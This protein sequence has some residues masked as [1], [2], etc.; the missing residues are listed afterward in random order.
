MAN[1][2]II[3]LKEIFFTELRELEKNFKKNLEEISSSL[4]EN[5]KQNEE[6]I[7]FAIQKNEQLYDKM[8]LE[9]NNLDK[10]G[11]LD[12]SQ[13]KLNDMIIS[14]EIKI[15][16][17]INSNKK[18]NL[19]YEKILSDNLTV[20]GFIGRSCIYKNLSEY[21]HHNI[22]DIER[23]KLEKEAEKKIVEDMKYKSDGL[24]KTILN[25]VENSVLRCNRYTDNKHK[26]IEEVLHNKLV[27]INEKNMDL[28]TQILTNLYATN[29]RVDNFQNQIKELK[30]MKETIKNDI[31]NILIDFHKKI[32][33]LEKNMENNIQKNISL[34][35][36]VLS[37]FISEIE[38]NIS[39]QTS[40]RQNKYG[41]KDY[42]S[43]TSYGKQ[44]REKDDLNAFLQ[45]KS[46]KNISAKL[47][48]DKFGRNRGFFKRKTQVFNA[49]NN[50][51]YMDIINKIDE[52]NDSNESNHSQKISIHNKSLEKE[53][54][55]ENSKEI[56]LIN[57]SNKKNNETEDYLYKYKQKKYSE[58]IEPKIN[59]SKAIDLNDFENDE[60]KE[61]NVSK[62]H[63]DSRSIILEKET[64]IDNK[65]KAQI[66]SEE[67]EYNN[68]SLSEKLKEEN[69]DNYQ[70]NNNK[71]NNS[72]LNHGNKNEEIIKE[73]KKELIL[74]PKEKNYNSKKNKVEEL[75]NEINNIKISDLFIKENKR[76]Q[77]ALS[78]NRKNIKIRNDSFPKSNSLIDKKNPNNFNNFKK[79]N[80]IENL[81]TETEKETILSKSNSNS[82]VIHKVGEKEKFMKKEII[83]ANSDRI[84]FNKTVSKF[85]IGEQKIVNTQTQTV[86]KTFNNLFP[87]LSLNFKLID[88][89]S[90]IDFTKNE[91]RKD[92][93]KEKTKDN[94]KLD[95]DLSSPLT[96]VY[97]A[98]H[99]QKM[100][101]KQNIINEL[102]IFQK[103]IP[104]N[105]T[106][107]FLLKGEPINYSISNINKKPINI[108][109][110]NNVIK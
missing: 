60:L 89:G 37:K 73:E 46:S 85:H 1:K 103:N 75:S 78:S 65:Q 53:K 45:I 48:E 72:D 104:A 12:I 68:D 97:K 96:N 33:D 101:A 52:N 10:I 19:K 87:K 34:F 32:E 98:Y 71:L 76:K 18:L 105:K 90:N 93:S 110:N 74:F 4:D 62:N 3:D 80:N 8:L 57:E 30:E 92:N 28:R 54:P 94:K 100:E 20:P 95:I 5:N 70:K 86:K 15:K 22:I 38:S 39:S 9:K 106:K 107:K 88:L 67:I 13:K 27:E 41:R 47:K 102:N 51:K 44:I 108:A 42:K 49:T 56:I 7:N 64:Q 23:I 61:E 58:Q 55:K 2:E 66:V 21:I 50:L 109:D 77:Q 91:L 36:N 43:S 31:D 24:M 99:K 79:K 6:K 26:Y 82:I 81:K 40:S 11:Q 35:K 25:L 69:F 63:N 59:L 16:E 84:I 29:Q 17:L 14:Q 83:L